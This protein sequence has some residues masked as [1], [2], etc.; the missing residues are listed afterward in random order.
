MITSINIKNILYILAVAMLLGFLYNQLSPRGIS[1]AREELKL[2]EY[3][4]SEE[5][6]DEADYSKIKAVKIDDAYS[7]FNEG[8]TFVD[9]RDMWE[10]SDGHITGAVNFPQIEFEIDHPALNEL[11]KNEKLIIY[12]S[13]DECGLS[14]KLAVE[15]QKLGYQKLFVFEEGWDAWLKKGYP[16]ETSEIE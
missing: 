14:T 5:I 4:G 6:N 8:V 3:N 13:S 10:F 2:D 9:A 12:C 11:K 16:T 1:L 7:M 15:L